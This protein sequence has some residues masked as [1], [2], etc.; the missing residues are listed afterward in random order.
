M[1]IIKTSKEINAPL[2]KVWSII[3]DV[4]KDPEY[5]FGTRS[6]KNIEKRGNTIERETIIAFRDSKCKEI[7]TLDEKNAINIDITEGP[8]TGKKTITI[9]KISDN[10]TKLNVVWDIH[11]AGIMG[12]FEFMVKKHI[13]KGT[14]EALGRISE[15]SEKI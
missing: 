13:L 6:I 7:V 14:E 3:S 5:W 12:L 8:V 4:D 11:M 9:E 10:K 2:D 1:T 15:K